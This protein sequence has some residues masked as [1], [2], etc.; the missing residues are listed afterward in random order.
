ML[1]F[2]LGQ[3]Y[4]KV[5]KVKKTKSFS[6]ARLSNAQQKVLEGYRLRFVLSTEET[7][8]LHLFFSPL[9]VPKG[10]SRDEVRIIILLYAMC[11]AHFREFNLPRFHRMAKNSL[12]V[13]LRVSRMTRKGFRKG[14]IKLLL[15][16]SK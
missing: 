8:H 4:K 12:P 2:Y 11:Y 7:A 15:A 3:K 16:L 14:I 6:E 13:E 10:L 9:R 5:V 1:V